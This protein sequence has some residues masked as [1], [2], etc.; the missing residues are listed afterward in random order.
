MDY[1]DRKV[2]LALIGTLLL[3]VGIP[4]AF[5]GPL[6]MYC[7]YLF[8]PNGPFHY[9]GFGWGSFMFGNIAAQIVGYYLIGIIGIVLGYGHFTARRWAGTLSLVLLRVWL[10]VGAPLVVVV[11]F[12]LLASKD[13]SPL[14]AG[15]ALVLLA[16]SY[17]LLPWM[18]IRFYESR[19]TQLTLEQDRNAYWIDKQP[20]SLLV[21]ETLLIFYI[22]MFH[23]PILFNGAFPLF[24][25]FRFGYE[26]ILLLDISIAGLVLLLWGTVGRK[27][28]AWW[29]ALVWFTL[30]TCSTVVT[31]LSSSYMEILAGMQFPATEVEILDGIPIEGIHLAL[32]TVPSL[33][34]TLYVIARARPHWRVA[35][36]SSSPP[37][38]ES[39][40]ES[41]SSNSR[42]SASRSSDAPRTS[43]DSTSVG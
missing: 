1:R 18:M 7:F 26:G 28:W 36:C 12:V 20:I 6:E 35:Y 30:V 4:T 31:L 43:A 38:R 40:C 10:V 34:A 3:A 15:A 32:L 42:T 17:L 2:A 13:I 25:R 41:G 33:L 11:F 29:G 5:L 39:T 9:D 24:G 23:I 22:V 21:L 16:L 14:A 19:D 8:G 37:K 27:A